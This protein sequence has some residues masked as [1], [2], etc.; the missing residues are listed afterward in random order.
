MNKTGEKNLEN[1][2]MKE[3]G[4]TV[5]LYPSLPRENATQIIICLRLIVFL[6]KT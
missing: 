4:E 2:G 1:Q 6:S 3:E 5:A